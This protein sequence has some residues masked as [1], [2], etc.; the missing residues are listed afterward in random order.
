MGK[1]VL[2]AIWR[3]RIAP[4]GDVADGLD[5]GK[6]VDNNAASTNRSELEYIAL[7]L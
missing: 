6:T 1:G 2:R 7:R 5:D 3:N 4:I